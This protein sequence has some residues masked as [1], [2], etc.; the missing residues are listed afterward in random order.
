M[1]PSAR[2]AGLARGALI[3]ASVAAL[4]ALAPAARAETAYRY[5]TYWS[6]TDGAW[7]F[8]TIGP[9]SAVPADGAVEGWRFAVTTAAGSAGDAPDAD[10]ATAF[11]SICGGTAPVAGM[12]RVA[13][14]VDFGVQQDA[15]AGEVFPED[16][17]ECVTADEAA[18][19]YEVLRSITD[20]RVGEGLVCGI[21]AYPRVECAEIVDETPPPASGMDPAPESTVAAPESSSPAAP[22]VSGV[23]LLVAAVI[24][25][26]AWRRRDRG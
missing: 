2:A 21:D 9:A 13:V 12:K 16:I 6:V 14:D 24:G 5:W 23:A 1:R 15:P 4:L 8:S 3:G 11:E 25:G 18:T 22:L 19:G 26:L 17:R 20:V 7:Q 10:P